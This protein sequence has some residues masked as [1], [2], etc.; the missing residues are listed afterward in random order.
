MVKKCFDKFLVSLIVIGFALAICSE[1]SADLTDG[2]VAH[3]PLDGDAIDES[4]YGNDGS[5]GSG[6]SFAEGIIGQSAFFAD[7]TSSG[8]TI[9]D[10]DILDTAV[11][12]R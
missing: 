12:F 1:V 2:L 9:P 3:Y 6:V 7:L 11:I 5:V 4:F 10:N 8:I